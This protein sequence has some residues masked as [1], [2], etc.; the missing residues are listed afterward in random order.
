M[1][2]ESRIAEERRPLPQV[3]WPERAR[4]ERRDDHAQQESAA[5]AAT[6]TTPADREIHIER[7]VTTRYATASSRFT[8]RRSRSRSGGY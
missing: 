2:S 5:R 8:L 7:G 3:A 4:K 1:G 6:V